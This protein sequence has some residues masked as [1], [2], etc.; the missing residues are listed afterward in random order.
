MKKQV[1]DHLS[2]APQKAVSVR[3]LSRQLK[4]RRP[5]E[6]RQLHVLIEDL[7]EQGLLTLD[8]R[9]NIRYVVERKVQQ[10]QHS[11]AHKVVGP[12]RVSRRGFGTVR[13]EG[14]KEEVSIAPRYMKTALHGDIVAVVLFARPA[15]QRVGKERGTIEGEIVE[16][17]KRTNLTVVGTVERTMHFT[18]V[19]PDNERFRRD[20]YVTGDQAG[21]LKPGDKVVVELLPWED[22]HLN[23]EGVIVEVLGPSGDARVEVLGVAR[24][25]GLPADFPEAV[26]REAALLP[27]EITRDDLVSR[28]DLRN[29]ICVTIDP[30]DA[31]DFDDALSYQDL[32]HGR[33]MLG[34]HIADVSRFVVEGTALDAEAMKRGTSVYLVNE[35][36]PMLPERL[37]TDLCSLRPDGDRLA[38]SVLIEVNA[39]GE[40]EDYTITESVIRSARRFT[41]EEVQKIIHDGR[42]ERAEMLLPLHEL[43]RILLSRRR[44]RGSLDFET[45]EA[46]FRFD[47][48]GF[49]SQIVPKHRLDSHRLVEE[50]MLLANSTVAQH[51]DR[52]KKDGQVTPFVYRVHDA[53]DPTRLRDLAHF[54]KQFG[55]SLDVSHGASAR[56]LQ[57]L[58]DKVE[59]R[60]IE[61]LINDVVLRSMAKAIYSEKNI[62]HYGLGYTHYTHFTSPI[63]R[64]PDL[65]V[66][67]L[68]KEYAQGMSAHGRAHLA[69]RLPDICRQSSERERIAQE[70][71]RTSV[72]VM[73]V[74]YMKRHVGDEF[75]GVIGGVTDFGIFVEINELLVEGLV[76]VRDMTDDYYLFDEKRYALKGRSR[77]K[78]YQLGDKARV[79]V[80]AVRPEDREIEFVL[81]E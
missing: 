78:V 67:R 35:V 53:P 20:I 74:E 57:K 71:E 36:V 45:A 68:L 66:H 9:G 27:G 76:R 80:V 44:R 18:V 6:L 4:I 43:S 29:T 55:L 75:D 8:H 38:F 70:A 1:L 51:I 15:R 14:M 62:G 5:D 50:C 21:R 58:L 31:N 33:V 2:R 10:S 72:K 25:F 11:Q 24:S 48:H 30:E 60:D 3:E 41:Y 59:G 47:M 13:V 17:V 81:V 42:G 19:V 52:L 37:S 79:Q 16:I 77:G 23:P 32:G 63:R 40:V 56:I 7:T 26:E 65:T 69:E 61:Y 22:E 39:K 46:K 34:V 73:Q 49:P 28:V 54:V 64:Y 12:L